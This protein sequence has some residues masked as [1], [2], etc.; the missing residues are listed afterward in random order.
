MGLFAARVIDDIS[1]KSNPDGMIYASTLGILYSF[2]LS[3][4]SHTALINVVIMG[5]PDGFCVF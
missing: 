4:Q 1:G 5:T 3:L 2:V